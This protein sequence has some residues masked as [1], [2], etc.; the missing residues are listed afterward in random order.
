VQPNFIRN[1]THPTP[2]LTAIHVYMYEP[3]TRQLQLSF[4]CFIS[5]YVLTMN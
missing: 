3:Q 2:P 5:S 4:P 1:A